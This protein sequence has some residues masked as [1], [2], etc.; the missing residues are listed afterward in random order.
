MEDW[1]RGV[2]N[3]KERGDTEVIVMTKVINK[4][5]SAGQ[6][7]EKMENERQR[8]RRVNG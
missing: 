8:E 3:T 6:T 1:Q 4:W 7:N 5:I 2:R